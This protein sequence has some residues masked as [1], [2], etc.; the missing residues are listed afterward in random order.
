MNQL[1]IVAS[2]FKLRVDGSTG[3]IFALEIDGR[4]YLITTRHI[5]ENITN[6]C[7]LAW[8]WVGYHFQLPLSDIAK[9]R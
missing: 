8:E 4:Q 7:E 1:D 3:T 9:A 6:G 2:T 5:A